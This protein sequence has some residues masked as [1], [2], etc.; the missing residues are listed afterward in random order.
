MSSPFEGSVPPLPQQPAPVNVAADFIPDPANPQIGV[1]RFDA[2]PA[3]FQ[4][5]LPSANVVPFL[6]SLAD[7][8]ERK[9]GPAVHVVRP[10]SGLFLPNGGANHG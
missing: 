5:I 9:L 7:N 4:L 10:V 3:S 6:R 1:L 2:G 8:T